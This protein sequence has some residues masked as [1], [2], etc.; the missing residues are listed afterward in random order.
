MSES[1]RLI[2]LSKQNQTI[3]DQQKALAEQLKVLVK[4]QK[5][6]LEENK[7]VVKQQQELINRL[8]D[9]LVVHDGQQEENDNFPPSPSARAHTNQETSTKTQPN[10]K[11]KVLRWTSEEEQALVKGVDCYGKES[12]DT[13]RTTY[14]ELASRSAGALKSKWRGLHGRKRLK[15]LRNRNTRST[16]TCRPTGDQDVQ[17]S[18]VEEPL[19]LTS[20]DTV[21]DE[22]FFRIAEYTVPNSLCGVAKL[23]RGVGAVSKNIRQKCHEYMKSV[24]LDINMVEINTGH[25][26]VY[27]LPAL[28]WVKERRAKLRSFSAFFSE[29]DYGIVASVLRDCNTSEIKELSIRYQRWSIVVD[30]WY[31][32]IPHTEFIS[33][34]NIPTGKTFREMALECG[35]QPDLIC[36]PSIL[37]PSIVRNAV[38]L[39]KLCFPGGQMNHQPFDFLT[40]LN[41]VEEL[42]VC[43]LMSDR[44]SRI[45]S[46]S[47]CE[48][49][50]YR[51][52]N[53]I[54]RMPRLRRLKISEPS[55]I[56]QKNY[57]LQ[58]RSE[59]L[60]VINVVKMNKGR[61]CDEV[62]CPSLKLFECKGHAYGNGI[63]RLIPHEYNSDNLDVTGTKRAGDFPCEGVSVPD[64]C[65]FKFER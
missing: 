59:T 35:V 5:S 30:Y 18:R 29:D 37:G 44:E 58:V 4:H 22:I 42:E 41:S 8:N 47:R 16:R 1:S 60:E 24:P 64:S 52:G 13:I 45:H 65:I 19:T 23:C 54:E 28:F 43:N 36:P 51:L 48:R 2:E 46:R 39:K 31:E 20:L 55:N 57:K 11:R 21:A 38:G 62:V 3:I 49:L 61:W 14:E 32:K 10:R 7:A 53:A 40:E 25:R 12:W 56:G 6:I 63:R 15:T 17:N 33:G 9:L 26:K 50:F 34:T 27:I